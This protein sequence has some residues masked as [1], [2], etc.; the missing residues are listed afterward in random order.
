MDTPILIKVINVKKY[1]PVYDEDI[2]H[3]CDKLNSHL[4]NVMYT[5]FINPDRPDSTLKK[6]D[7]TYTPYNRFN[8]YL[9]NGSC[10]KYTTDTYTPYCNRPTNITDN[11][12]TIC[13]NNVIEQ[14]K[15][16][17]M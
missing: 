3:V 12:I 1:K 11:Q 17:N 5:W 4:N 14:L 13:K 8:E 15:L 9:N 16:I 2:V 7:N 6:I 10:Q